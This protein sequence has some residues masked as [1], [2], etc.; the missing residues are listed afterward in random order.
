MITFRIEPHP[1]VNLS[2]C[3]NLMV[4]RSEDNKI[5][6]HSISYRKLKIIKERMEKYARIFSNNT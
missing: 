4:L 2:S 1:N 6:A 5:H 3:K